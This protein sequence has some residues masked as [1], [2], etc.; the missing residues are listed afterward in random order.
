MQLYYIVGKNKWKMCWREHVLNLNYLSFQSFDFERT[1]W[2]LFQKRVVRTKFNIYVFIKFF[3]FLFLVIAG[4]ICIDFECGSYY[5]GNEFPELGYYYLFV[6]LPLIPITKPLPYIQCAQDSML[7]SHRSVV[8]SIRVIT[9][10]PNSMLTSI[11]CY[12][13]NSIFFSF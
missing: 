7:Y 3:G 6:T 13:W 2:R 12:C 5:C 8:V 4:I 9:K 11:P 1:W 10:L